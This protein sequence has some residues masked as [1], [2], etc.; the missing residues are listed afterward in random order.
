MK[1]KI[2]L[3]DADSKI[4]NIALMKLSTYYKSRNYEIKLMR[5]NIAYYP[6]LLKKSHQIDTS[7]YHKAFCSIIFPGSRRYVHGDNIIYGGT[8]FNLKTKLPHI[9]ESCKPDYSIYPD[10]QYNYGYISRGCIRNCSFCFVPEKE[11]YI[12]QTN[13]PRDIITDQFNATIFMDNNIL[14]LPNHMEILKYLV[15]SKSKCRFEQGLDIRLINKENSQLLS[16]LSYL[17]EYIFAF[18]NWNYKNIIDEKLPLLS[19]ASKWRLRF[20]I[21]V[22]PSM[23]LS[24]TIKR[25][26]YMK[27]RKHLVYIMRDISCWNN[28]YNRFYTTIAAWCNQPS[29]FRKK[30]FKEYL[31]IR[32][33]GKDQRRMGRQW[34]MAI[35][36]EL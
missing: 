23:P 25:I 29:I 15:D 35:K 7:N 26:M 36:G 28:K 5:L 24:N 20:Y 11:G 19:W 34:D 9:I 32:S 2:L 6:S 22:H 10:C 18:D 16:Q 13:H 1:K 4:P 27:E 12:Y 3:I 14:A 30:T 8:G 17:K 21:Y 33:L 31:I